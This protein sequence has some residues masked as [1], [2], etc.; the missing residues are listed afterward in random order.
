MFYLIACLFKSLYSKSIINSSTVW[1]RVAF[2]FVIICAFSPISAMI[3]AIDYGRYTLL[4]FIM[5][6]TDFFVLVDQERVTFQMDDLYLF[7]KKENRNVL[8]F[9][10]LVCLAWIGPY[11]VT[12]TDSLVYVSLWKEYF[13]QLFIAF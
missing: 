9:I 8:P 11:Y 5:L 6:M 12:A 13:E 2:A 1:K 7:N 4:I 10:I 3:I